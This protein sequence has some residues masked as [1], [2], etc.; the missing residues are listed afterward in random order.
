MN[1]IAYLQFLTIFNAVT[2]CYQASSSA[3]ATRIMGGGVFDLPSPGVGVNVIPLHADCL[4]VALGLGF[5]VC[6]MVPV[7]RVHGRVAVAHDGHT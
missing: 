2:R 6:W 1:E 3:S 4:G 7:K 5:D